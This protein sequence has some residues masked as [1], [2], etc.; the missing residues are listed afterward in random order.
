MIPTYERIGISETVIVAV[1]I[2]PGEANRRKAPNA[3]PGKPMIIA[4]STRLK[5]FQANDRGK[6]TKVVRAMNPNTRPRKLANSVMRPI[7][8]RMWEI[9]IKD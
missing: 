3:L 2:L 7:S 5:R 4:V 1:L 9:H 8:E 6:A